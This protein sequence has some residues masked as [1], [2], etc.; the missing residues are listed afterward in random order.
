MAKMFGRSKRILNRIACGNSRGSTYV[1]II[2]AITILGLIVAAVPPAIIFSTKAVFAQQEKTVSEMLARS[3]AEYLKYCKY[4]IANK[5]A[6]IPDYSWANM[7]GP[8]NS[9]YIEISASAI[10]PNQPLINEEYQLASETASLYGDEDE[11]YDHGIQLVN[12]DIYHVERL[13][14]STKCFKVNR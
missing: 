12:V 14:L 2:V 10:D 8:D 1:E 6:Q 13:V 11:D 3:Q 9:Y 5:S 4:D 7:S